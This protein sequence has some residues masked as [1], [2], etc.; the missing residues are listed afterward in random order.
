MALLPTE[1]L[2]LSSFFFPIILLLFKY[3]YL[4]LPPATPPTTPAIPTSLP[5]FHPTL[6]LS[7][8]PLYMFL[9]TL[10]LFPSIIPSYLPFGYCQIVLN[11]N[12]SGYILLQHC[13]YWN[14]IWKDVTCLYLETLS[15][16]NLWKRT[17]HC[18]YC[19]DVIIL[20]FHSQKQPTEE[21]S[22]WFHF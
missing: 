2:F 9:K 13:F 7:M 6:V 11:F 14:V 4:H 18:T 8:C 17:C 20:E 16:K 19:K 3:S 15:G 1:A 21:I 12:A 10:S 22:P 5:C